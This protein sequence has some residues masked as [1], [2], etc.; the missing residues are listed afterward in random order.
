MTVPAPA[1]WEK[2]RRDGIARMVAE[3]P[4]TVWADG[5]KLMT[6]GGHT[7][8]TVR[9][10]AYCEDDTWAS[11]IAQAINAQGIPTREGGDA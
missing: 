5:H 9:A 3:E 4:N 10:I 8:H 2:V 7:G 1:D 6:C 11:V